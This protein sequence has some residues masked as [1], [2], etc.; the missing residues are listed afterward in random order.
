MVFQNHVSY[1]PYPETLALELSSRI[2]LLL[3]C[4]L[5]AFRLQAQDSDTPAAKHITYVPF[6]MLTG[7]VIIIH[8]TLD[9]YPDTLNFVL[10]TGSGGISLDSAT[11]DYL[12]IRREKSNVMI[13]GIAGVRA[14]EYA[15]NHRLNLKGVSA[16]NLDFHINDYD[17]LT[18]VYGIKIDGIIGYTF[19]RRYLVVINYEKYRL[20]I[21]SQGAYKYPR[22]GHT[23]HPRFSTLPVQPVS[24]KEQQKLI[25]NFYF[26]TGAGLCFLL[27]EQFAK[28]SMVFNDR[29]KSYPTLAQ[30]LGGKA[31]MNITTLKE[32]KIGPYRFRNVPA[33]IFNDP[34]NATSYPQVSGLIGN[35]LMRRFT[36]ILNYAKR[37]IYIKPNSFYRDSFD[38][39]YTGLGI[40]M[41]DKK[42]TVLDIMKNSPAEKAGLHIGDV[43]VGVNKDFTNNIQAYKTALQSAKT[44][45]NL[46][47]MREG[48]GVFTILLKVRSIF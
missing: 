44:T 20:E 16:D 5:V 18:S 35:D 4:M 34:Y 42:I 41:V 14:V 39:S 11:C 43:I 25:S 12:H 3:G 32:V 13:K 26:D 48:E 1:L 19:L 45:Q 22:G 40:Y 29:K 10:D 28:D 9:N 33:Y 46:L 21:L 17:I 37:E 2:I 23:L 6:T 36:V 30:G 7:G 24:I 31:E 27:S 38:Y 8:A 47:V 15:Y